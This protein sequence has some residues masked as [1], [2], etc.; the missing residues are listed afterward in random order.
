MVCP[1]DTTAPTITCSPPPTVPTGAGVCTAP[2]NYIVTATDNCDPNPSLVCVPPAPGPFSAGTT[3]VNC[4]ATDTA[5]NNSACSFTVTVLDTLPPVLACNVATTSLW[6]ANN[7]MQNVGF[8]FTATDACSPPLTTKVKVY[9]DEPG[10][11]DA[12][13]GAGILN[14]RR[15]R[16]GGQDGRV[17]LIVVTAT[18]TAGNISFCGR[19]VVVPKANSAGWVANANA[20]AAAALA[21]CTLTGSPLMPFY[22][23]K[24]I[25]H[26]CILELIRLRWRREHDSLPAR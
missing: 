4:T 15:A 18:D 11:T 20:Q 22:R 23:V 8:T 14:L 3:P 5:G 7:Q 26:D 16:D 25:T 19:T 6:P 1:P 2:V 12:T 13:Y 9:S 21:S 10:V 24:I 17:Y